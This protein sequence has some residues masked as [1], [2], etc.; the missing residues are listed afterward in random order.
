[1]ISSSA[2]PLH[3]RVMRPSGPNDD[4]C[5]IRSM[6]WR[7]QIAGRD[8]Q[9]PVLVGAA[10]AGQ[11]VEQLRRVGADL[12]VAREDPEV[13]VDPRRLRVVVAGAD[14]AVAAEPVAVVAHDEHDLGVRLQTDHAVDD[15][16]TGAFELPRPLHVGRLVE[17]R[18]E[19][20][21]H[22]HLHASLGGADQAPDD[23]AV[24]T[25]AVQRHLDRLHPRI[26]GGLA[27]ER[28]DARG[29]ALVG[30]MD[31]QG[32]VADDVEDRAGCRSRPRRCGRR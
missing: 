24:A 7:L 30:V 9:R 27:D 20:D 26:V 21:E 10:V 8:E 31:E 14:V 29:E 17:S 5:S 2:I 18:L 23:G 1:M 6:S 12:V 3:F 32:A 4:S 25:G 15:V 22:R 11:V 19:L 28:L 13:F 16:H